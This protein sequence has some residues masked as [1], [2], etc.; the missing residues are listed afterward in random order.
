MSSSSTSSHRC[1]AFSFSLFISFSRSHSARARSYAP[2]RHE[3]APIVSERYTG[4]PATSA[5]CIVRFAAK[6]PQEVGRAFHALDVSGDHVG[7]KRSGDAIFTAPLRALTPPPRRQPRPRH[8]P[9]QNQNPGPRDGHEP[10]LRRRR[11]R[12]R[13]SVP[14]RAVRRAA[15]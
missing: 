9:R 1:L 15:T 4:A 14:D 2:G 13:G 7:S 8:H 6:D 5:P 11:R 12:R 10:L 3:V